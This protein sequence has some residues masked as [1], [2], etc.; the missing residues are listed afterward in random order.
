MK[1]YEIIILISDFIYML[2]VVS[3]LLINRAKLCILLIIHHIYFKLN[4][5]TPKLKI[6]IKKKQ[7]IYLQLALGN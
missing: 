5:I 6:I 7:V 1:G 3:I 2:V 4:I